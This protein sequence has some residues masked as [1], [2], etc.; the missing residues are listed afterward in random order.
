MFHV[1]KNANIMNCKQLN[2]KQFNEK[3]LNANNMNVNE[4]NYGFCVRCKN[5]GHVAET[6]GHEEFC[7]FKQCLCPKCNQHVII[8]KDNNQVVLRKYNSNNKL[9]TSPSLTPSKSIESIDKSIHNSNNNHV[10]NAISRESVATNGFRQ[11]PQRWAQTHVTPNKLSPTSTST[12]STST[13]RDPTEA[14]KVFAKRLSCCGLDKN[15]VQKA[16]LYALLK[17]ND[18]NL[19]QTKRKIRDAGSVFAKNLLFPLTYDAN[20]EILRAA[21]NANTSNDEP[22]NKV[23]KTELKQTARKSIKSLKS[24]FK[25]ILPKGRAEFQ[26][27]LA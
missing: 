3:Q 8:V 18:L 15:D 4:E 13:S 9:N 12:T 6:V 5:H 17:K 16:V 23:L 22:P 10:V 24:P 26:L 1:T 11:M 25:K 27:F 2:Q 7:P 21:L 14:I 19:D 20:N